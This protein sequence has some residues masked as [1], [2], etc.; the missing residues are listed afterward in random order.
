M[1]QTDERPGTPTL[2]VSPA[3]L[4]DDPRVIAAL[5]EYLT[6][7]RAGQRPN[8]P[9]FVARHPDI[10]GALAEC[11]DGLEFVH[12]AAPELS[13]GSTIRAASTAGVHPGATPLG[14][15]RI[16]REIGRGGMGVVYE[17]E[18]LSLGRHVALKVLPFAAALDAKHLQRFKNE[19]QAAAQL[20]HTNIVP[21]FGVGCERGVHYYAM[22]YIEGQT[23]GALIRELRQLSGREAAGE[24]GKDGAAQALAGE[25]AS[26]Q[27]APGRG[28]AVAEPPTVTYTG[29]VHAA[30]LPAGAPAAPAAETAVQPA[31]AVTTQ[32]SASNPAFF[33]TVANLG[34]QA[35][36]AL[37]HAH[38]QGII[39]RD[40]KP[41]NLLVDGR[42]KLWITDFG[43]AYFRSDAALTMTG[44]LVG[45]LRYMS[46]EQALAKRAMVDHRTDIYSL[47]ATL[48]ELLALEPAFAGRDRE[49]LLRQIAFDEVRPPRRLNRAVPAELETIVLKAMAKHPDERYATAGE[50]ADDLRRYL[51][52]RPIRARRPL[53]WQRVQKW[54]RRHKPVVASAA[55]LL[56]MAVVS[57]AASTVLVWNE[58]DEARRQRDQAQVQRDEADR[59]RKEAQA[60]RDQANRL[61]KEA[62]DQRK[63]AGQA[64]D[65]LCAQ[66]ERPLSPDAPGMETAQR[67]FLEKALRY[68]QAFARENRAQRG[69]RADTATAYRRVGDIQRAL[70]RLPEAE[71]AYREAIALLGSLA[72]EHPEATEHRLELAGDHLRLGDLLTSAGRAGEAKEAYGRAAEL[73]GKLGAKFPTLKV[74]IREI[75]VAAR[76]RVYQN[77]L[78]ESADGVKTYVN[79]YA[80]TYGPTFNMA[81]AA[82]RPSPVL[83]YSAK[84]LNTML[85]D[86]QQRQSK[87]LLTMPQVVRLAVEDGMLHNINVTP[88]HET[89]NL[90]LLKNG[91]RLTWPVALNEADSKAERTR[92]ATLSDEALRQAHEKGK[93][94][95][96]VIVA[97]EK[98]VDVLHERLV[99]RVQDLTPTQ[100][101]E[102]KRFLDHLGQA[103]KT[104]KQ[105]DVGNYFNGTYT[106]KG[107]NVAELVESMNK[108]GLRFAPAAPGDE[109]A[110]L[111]LYQVLSDA[112][113][114][115][116]GKK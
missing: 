94:E 110:Y 52:D 45:T 103:V 33:R 41:A 93:V 27:W 21:V 76:Q 115:G 72:T 20:H 87:G 25:L 19:A 54:A 40:I 34:V 26:G 44:D 9:E 13:Q 49:E 14:D 61:R 3:G 59:L 100:Y 113:A 65:E 83:I 36:E 111:Q 2:N 75:K 15:F 71:T 91:G 31:A 64:L 28:R 8:R 89:G 39:H 46:P 68:Y 42:G 84:T 56:V 4:P 67:D 22:Q 90:G 69:M 60:Q 78:L 48:Y 77:Y 70:K 79:P 17:A 38:E 62:E 97:M 24:Q 98:D 23:L 5:E 29:P 58:R 96:P 53:V 112:K 85:V 35:A 37:E 95:A 73:F 47:G 116:P 74:Q 106:P 80:P 108:K 66:I 63:L 107:K 11:L 6:A 10:A 81:Y 16:L 105:P 50:L 102:A 114:G 92:L 99:E 109:P 51:E 86:L 18:Q 104:L 43:L 32:R 82:E 1:N 88:L 12:A 7:L 57:L 101:M 55:G 30:V